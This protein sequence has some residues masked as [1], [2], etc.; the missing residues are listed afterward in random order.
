[1]TKTDF[2]SQLS[3]LDSALAMPEGMADDIRRT[4]DDVYASPAFLADA[5]TVD[6]D[7][8][9][10]EY[11]IGEEMCEYAQ[12]NGCDPRV[13]ALFM[14]IYHSVRTMR[15]YEE[16]S[17]SR[18]VYIDTMRDIVLW[19]DKAGGRWGTD[20]YK[21][22]VLGMKL[23]VFRI[24]RF[25]YQPCKVGSDAIGDCGIVIG[26]HTVKNGDPAL[27]IH[28]PN[29]EPLTRELR[30][31]SYRAAYRFFSLTGDAVFVCES[32]LLYE[33]NRDMLPEG[34]NIVSFMDDFRLLHTTE[35]GGFGE[36][37]R[38]FG[39]G[40]DCTKP[41]TLPR[42]TTVQRAYADRIASGGKVG[43]SY[44]IFVHDGEKRKR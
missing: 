25:E 40:C 1:M 43:E 19:S 7:L 30:E 15:M 23:K 28:I 37:W 18:E 12:K 14:C 6:T 2:L 11:A 20:S 38:I 26:G 10:G 41:E 35:S 16:R 5:E 3:M 27:N 8:F 36:M 24:G 39:S 32:W 29:G 21:W 17:L 31:S 9:A 4:A 34:S 33:A 42:A 22:I 44:G 13:F